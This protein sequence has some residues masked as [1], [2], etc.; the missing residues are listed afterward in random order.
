MYRINGRSS[1]ILRQEFPH[2]RDRCEGHL[3]APGFCHGPG[4]V[5]KYISSQNC[6]AGEKAS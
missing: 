3:L 5:E 6:S 4:V 2:L 1:R